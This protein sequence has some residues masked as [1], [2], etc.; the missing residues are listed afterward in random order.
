VILFD[1]LWQ[2]HCESPDLLDRD[3]NM[4]P[5]ISTRQNTGMPL[6]QTDELTRLEQ[7]LDHI[8]EAPAERGTVE[9]I[10]RRPA[11]DEREV[12]AEGVLD[13][14]VGLVGDTWIA[15]GSTRTPDGSPNLEA[16]LT[17]MNAR[18]AAAVAGDRQRW[19]LAGDQLYVDFDISRANLPAGTRVQIGTAV[20]EFSEAP[21]TGCDKF[22]ARF[23]VDA[24]R[25]VNSPIGRE[26]RLRGA[27]C[28]V[29]VAGTVRAGDEIRKLPA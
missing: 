3:Q 8:R 13:S 27:N 25:F 9:L 14:E 22:S 6:G 5:A 2:G 21:H 17:V 24:L 1:S 10:A 20:I 15:R 12:L 4:M 11:E 23:G 28:R 18:V 29:M 26:L 16:Q 7:S 19:A